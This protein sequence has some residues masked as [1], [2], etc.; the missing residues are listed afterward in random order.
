MTSSDMVATY[1]PW[2]L[3]AITIWF[4]ILAGNKH[5]G[6]WGIAMTGQLGW[7]LWI[8]VTANWGFL[9]MNI[10]LWVVYARNHWKWVSEPEGAQQ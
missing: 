6:A 8:V 1:M 10:A 4:N 5:R 2:L 9:P 7:L 3:S